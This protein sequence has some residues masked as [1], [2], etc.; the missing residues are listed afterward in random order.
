MI[1]VDGQSGV[2][3]SLPGQAVQDAEPRADN[4]LV[5]YAQ[6]VD[7]TPQHCRLLEVF[8]LHHLDLTTSSSSLNVCLGLIVSTSE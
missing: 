8:D 5:T 1:D 7:H 2:E 4:H 3:S 6:Y